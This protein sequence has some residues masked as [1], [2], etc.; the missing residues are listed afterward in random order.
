MTEQA[1]YY[2]TTQTGHFRDKFFM[3]LTALVLTN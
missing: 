1:A 2:T 3:Q